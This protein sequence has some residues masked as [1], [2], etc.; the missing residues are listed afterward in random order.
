MARP[1]TFPPA[2]RG[3][4]RVE[5]PDGICWTQGN[6]TR[7]NVYDNQSP[8]NIKTFETTIKPQRKR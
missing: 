8:F 3:E 1:P 6:E 2:P 5:T 4:V 7:S